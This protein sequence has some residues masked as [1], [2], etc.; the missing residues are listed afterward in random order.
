MAG[1]YVIYV[2][3]DATGAVTGARTATAAIQTMSSEAK[4][5]TAAFGGL[6]S[7][8]ATLGFLALGH[9]VYEAAQAFTAVK[10]SIGAATQGVGDQHAI[11]EQLYDIAQRTRQP[12]DELAASFSRLTLFTKNLH[13]SQS[14]ILEILTEFNQAVAISGANSQSAKNGIQQLSKALE[15]GKVQG[16]TYRSIIRDIP[17]FMANVARAS[18]TTTSALQAL[19]TH[20]SNGSRLFAD[21]ILR[22]SKSMDNL[23]QHTSPTIGQLGT[24]FRNLFVAIDEDIEHST[25][26]F[27]LITTG[28]SNFIIKLRQVIPVLAVVSIAFGA[29][30]LDIFLQRALAAQRAAF[31]LGGSLKFLGGSM[32]LMVLAVTAAIALMGQFGDSY[33]ITETITMG[34]VARALS[35]VLGQNLVAAIGAVITVMAAW[36]LSQTGTLLGIGVMILSLHQYGVAWRTLIPIMGG[37]A[38]IMLIVNRNTALVKGAFGLLWQAAALLVSGLTSLVGA[39]LALD[40]AALLNPLGLAIIGFGL[41]AG[42]VL[43]LSGAF[44]KIYNWLKEKLGTA[45]GF[46]AFLADKLTKKLEELGKQSDDTGNGMKDLGE[47][48]LPKVVNGM[49]DAN[50]SAKELDKTLKALGLDEKSLFSGPSLKGQLGLSGLESFGANS[51]NVQTTS[52]GGLDFD[53][54]L[55]AI[56][57]AEAAQKAAGEQ[58]RLAAFAQEQA[59]STLAEVAHAQA[60]TAAAEAEAAKQWQEDNT[61]ASGLESVVN[62]MLASGFKQESL[63]R[64]PTTGAYT[65]SSDTAQGLPIFGNTTA[66]DLKKYFD[67]TLNKPIEDQAAKLNS[68]LEALKGL[69]GSG[70]DT[71][72]A[73]MKLI[74]LQTGASAQEIAD[75]AKTNA[76]QLAVAEKIH[77]LQAKADARQ[78]A[79]DAAKQ[80]HDDSIKSLTLEALNAFKVNKN[81]QLGG[82]VHGLIN[83][84][85]SE[86][87]KLSGLTSPIAQAEEGRKIQVLTDKLHTLTG[88]VDKNTN[89]LNGNENP[90][91]KFAQNVYD[92]FIGIHGDDPNT[93]AANGGGGGHGGGHHGG[94]HGGGGHHGGQNLGPGVGHG[95]KNSKHN[96]PF[97]LTM[98][99]HGVKDT[100]GFHRSRKQILSAAYRALMKAGAEG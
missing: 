58:A 17:P 55:Q 81:S 89:A 8:F 96:K 6:K 61:V 88:A 53:A 48:K 78:Q 35:V 30:K 33:P 25:G 10:S 1:T 51:S 26:A 3:V 31:A 75:V 92:D 99:I 91:L 21:A 19:V 9:E 56:R 64:D 68:I 34:T 13:L 83:R 24:Q 57:D 27:T 2:T 20:T 80:A 54:T 86:Q 32:G 49:N 67:Q 5:T 7:V 59:A 37:L 70:T 87:A 14:D 77:T 100:A 43:Y 97:Y 46:L 69:A 76:K 94:G 12:V 47:D 23:F 52:G 85:A 73:Q 29:I 28:I 38:I 39:I 15:E 63:Q 36:R 72:A 41:L 16:Q 62:G 71:N 74:A 60:A 82:D 84:I 44:E 93:F 40:F 95:G 66:E 79:A 4:A 98:N 90:Y 45:M 65:A 22:A 18:N 11:F 42:A 50:T